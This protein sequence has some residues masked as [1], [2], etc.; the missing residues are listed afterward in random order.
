MSSKPQPKKQKQKKITFEEAEIDP[1]LKEI[2]PELGKINKTKPKKGGAKHDDDSDNIDSESSDSDNEMEEQYEEID[3]DDALEADDEEDDEKSLDEEEEDDKDDN[4]DDECMYRFSGKKSSLGDD[5]DGDGDQEFYFE[6]DEKII[7][8][9]FVTDDKRITRPTLTKFERVR[10]LGER[11]KQLS[12][13]AK[14]MVKGVE[15]LDPKEI[16]KL[17]LKMGV[18]P[19][20]I[21]R[22]LPT[23]QKE[24]WK[25]NELQIVN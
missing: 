2:F 18:L 17:E 7:Q 6:E 19:I 1:K 10:V 4:G 11:A 25:V 15:K 5:D 16:A 22:T 14:P 12:L 21:I 13:N 8:N 9:K 24:R 20:I 3:E 23:G